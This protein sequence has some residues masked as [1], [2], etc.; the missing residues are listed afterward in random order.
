MVIG[1][2]LEGKIILK[3]EHLEKILISC[4]LI[5][6]KRTLNLVMIEFDDYYGHKVSLHIQCLLRIF[7]KG[8]LI[9]SSNDIYVKKYNSN[10]VQFDW[11]EPNSSLFDFLISR[12]YDVLIHRNIKEIQFYRNDIKIYLTNEIEIQ[13][14]I[15]S[16]ED[17]EKYR[18]F[19]DK[20]DLLI[21]T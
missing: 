8:K 14:L 6:I 7:E 17:D 15:D 13:V 3:K 19:D 10:K 5:D 20:R 16:V 12:Y 2:E 1:V 18:F 11:T 9:V 21:V 4:K